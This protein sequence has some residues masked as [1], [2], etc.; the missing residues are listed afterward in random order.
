MSQSVA[1]RK[2]PLLPRYD[3]SRIMAARYLASFVAVLGISGC[4]FDA[5]R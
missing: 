2:E 4:D 1:S 3:V 5:E